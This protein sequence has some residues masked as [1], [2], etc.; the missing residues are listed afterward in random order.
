LEKGE[1]EHTKGHE[2]AWGGAPRA[3]VVSG[4]TEEKKKK[5]GRGRRR[6][7]EV[8]KIYIPRWHVDGP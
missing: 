3:F 1:H 2:Q 4:V 8:E 5:K 7:R 6:R